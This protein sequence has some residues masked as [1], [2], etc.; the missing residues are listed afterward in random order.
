MSEYSSLT[1][2]MNSSDS[3]DLPKGVSSFLGC[4]MMKGIYTSCIKTST[5]DESPM[6]Y[7]DINFIKEHISEY[8][9]IISVL[10]PIYIISKLVKV[11]LCLED[12]FLLKNLLQ[13]HER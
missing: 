8:A 6:A 11:L 1:L 13:K 12:L 2:N 9:N 4:F 5:I 7:K 10:K 3:S